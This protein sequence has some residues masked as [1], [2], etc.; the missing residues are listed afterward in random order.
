MCR[1]ENLTIGISLSVLL[2]EFVEERLS[3]VQQRL[4]IGMSSSSFHS[5]MS[6]A[7]IVERPIRE[8]L[9]HPIAKDKRSFGGGIESVCLDRRMKGHG[10]VFEPEE[11]EKKRGFLGVD[12]RV[13]DVQSGTGPMEDE[14]TDE[15]IR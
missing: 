12:N 9:S 8:H 13:I 3:V 6:T 5:Q 1:T 7:E 10:S 4:D 11:F 15:M 14:H 2:G